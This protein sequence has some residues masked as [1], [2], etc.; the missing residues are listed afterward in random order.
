MRIFEDARGWQFTVR[1]LLGRDTYSV[2]YRKPNKG[3]NRT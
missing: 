2:F 1:P 3:E